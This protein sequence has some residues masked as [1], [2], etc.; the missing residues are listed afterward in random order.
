MLT[1]RIYFEISYTQLRL[2]NCKSHYC[3]DKHYLM[4]HH[5]HQ[6]RLLRLDLLIFRNWVGYMTTFS[7]LNLESLNT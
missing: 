2:S 4:N 3:S 5:Y 7:I 1:V 6:E